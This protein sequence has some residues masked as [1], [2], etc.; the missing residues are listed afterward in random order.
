[1]SLTLIQ[2]WHERA[3]PEPTD[4]NFNTQLGCHIEEIV[5]M[6]DTLEFKNFDWSVCHNSLKMLATALKCGSEKATITDR[7]EFLDSLADQ[8]VTAVGTGHCTGMDVSTACLRVNTSNWTKYGPTGQP[9]FN[10]SGKIM[11]GD[12]YKPPKLEGLY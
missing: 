11:K 10:E 6:L 5:E 4:V 3:R 2:L 8:V 9:V 1:M 7:K 12:N